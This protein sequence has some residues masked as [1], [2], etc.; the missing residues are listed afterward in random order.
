MPKFI[1]KLLWTF[2]KVDLTV[3]LSLNM[4][5]MYTC[6]TCSVV[7]KCFLFGQCLAEKTLANRVDVNT[8]SLSLLILATYAKYA[9]AAQISFL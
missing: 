1:F 2:G 8:S 5:K 9:S 3:F 4:V 6:P 7:H